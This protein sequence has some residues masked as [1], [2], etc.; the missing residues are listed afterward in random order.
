MALFP[1]RVHHWRQEIQLLFLR[2]TGIAF[3]PAFPGLPYELFSFEV[4]KDVFSFSTDLIGFLGVT[5]NFF[6]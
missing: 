4:V 6:S 5:K 2:R 1:D 3:H